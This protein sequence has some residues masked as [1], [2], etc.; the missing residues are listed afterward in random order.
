MMRARLR[1]RVGLVSRRIS[2]GAGWRIPALPP[3][4]NGRRFTAPH[5][6]I[7]ADVRA[8]A[9]GWSG[10]LLFVLLMLV[11]WTVGDR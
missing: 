3:Y 8:I 11:A 1:A 7:L 9:A 5:G 4:T 10:L 2:S 6:F